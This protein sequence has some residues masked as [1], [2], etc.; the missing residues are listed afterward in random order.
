MANHINCAAVQNVRIVVYGSVTSGS[1]ISIGRILHSASS[2]RVND[3]MSRSVMYMTDIY[4]RRPS[5]QTLE[6]QSEVVLHNL[7]NFD[8]YV[9]QHSYS[10][11]DND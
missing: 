10:P 9:F 1:Q 7:R 4:G 8:V 2:G 3:E 11:M 5:I 6:Y